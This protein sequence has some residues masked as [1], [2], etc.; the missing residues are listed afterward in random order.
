MPKMNRLTVLAAALALAASAAHAQKVP[1]AVKTAASAAEKGLKKAEGAVVH[2]AKVASEGVQFGVGK[3]NEVADATARR[4]GLP[5]GPAP[6]PAPRAM[7]D[8]KRQ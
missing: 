1:D 2:A 3:A 4:L 6:S 5:T 7:A 8:A